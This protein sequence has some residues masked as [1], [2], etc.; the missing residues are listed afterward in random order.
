MQ[1]TKLQID[2]LTVDSFA[3]DPSAPTQ[4]GPDFLYNGNVFECTGCVSGCG[5]FYEPSI[6]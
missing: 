4:D 2:S 5:I 1:P 3:T 6:A